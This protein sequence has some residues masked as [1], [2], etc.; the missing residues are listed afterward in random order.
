MGIAFLFC[1]QSF[2]FSATAL[3]CINH[4]SYLGRMQLYGYPQLTHYTFFF[5]FYSCHLNPIQ[6]CD[7]HIMYVLPGVERYESNVLVTTIL[8]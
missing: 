4:C 1:L 8:T 3:D 2:A 7:V 6:R 5:Q